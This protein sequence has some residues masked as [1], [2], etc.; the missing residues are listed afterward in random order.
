[1]DSGEDDKAVHRQG[2]NHSDIAE[3]NLLRD[4]SD[5]SDS[6]VALGADEL[7]FRLLPLVD[8]KPWPNTAA[9]SPEGAGGSV[10]SVLTE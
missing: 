2:M 5:V 3:S 1:M 9:S 8:T 7:R 4:G 6:I 10:S